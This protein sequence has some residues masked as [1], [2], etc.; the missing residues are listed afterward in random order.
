MAAALGGGVV[1]GVERL[2]GG[3]A[4]ATHGFV[5]QQAETSQRLVL[6]RYPPGDVTPPLEWD[7]LCCARRAGVVTPVP[8]ALDPAGDWFGAPSLVMSR[9]PGDVDLEPADLADW[10]RQL[11]QA[12][13]AIHRSD[14]GSTALDTLR[15]PY[16]VERW[17][18]WDVSVNARI[19]A[20]SA[21][22]ARL[23]RER[24]GQREVFCHADFHPGNVLFEA[25]T[26]SGVIDWSAARLAPPALDVAHCRADLAIF[27][28]GEAPALFL[29]AYRD[30]SSQPLEGLALWEVFEGMHALK[31][32][33][34]WVDAFAEEG[35]TVTAEG[36]RASIESFLDGALARC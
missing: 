8:T 18:L 16:R 7:R 20:A 12:L 9:V 22:I 15:R 31:W 23:Q 21:A 14:P 17:Q 30:A 6:K 33:P 2:G 27:P 36:M 1:S 3:V 32:S 25:G 11:A 35:V 10:T 28:G 29:A 4:A 24:P 26:L 34:T 19:A 5:L 13:A